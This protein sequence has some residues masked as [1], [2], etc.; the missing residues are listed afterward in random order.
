MIGLLEISPAGG[1]VTSE[2]IDPTDSALPGPGSQVPGDT[3]RLRPL[4]HAHGRSPDAP[5]Q[6]GNVIQWRM[7]PGDRDRRVA[8]TPTG[9]QRAAVPGS[10]TGGRVK[11]TPLD[12]TRSL[13]THSVR[14]ALHLGTPAFSQLLKT[15]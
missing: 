14:Q 15:R 12:D 8:W 7:P 3:I 4:T 11:C 6:P 13:P 9:V 1:E 2:E 10:Q 5:R